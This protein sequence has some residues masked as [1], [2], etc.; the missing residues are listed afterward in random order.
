MLLTQTSFAED[1]VKELPPLNPIYMG[2]QQMVLITHGSNIYASHLSSYKTP[3]NFQLLYK[4][5]NKNVA[6][7][8]T[9]KNNQL[10]TI[11]SKPFNIQRLMRG[12]KVTV[13]VDLYTGHFDRDGMV[14]Y[15]GISLTFDKQLYFR[16]F[17]EIKPSNKRQDYD[18]VSL[19]GG[20]RFYIHQIQK[21]PS[22]S[23]ILGVDL[24][25]S[26]LGSFSTSSP[27]PEETEL[28]FKFINC[29]TIKPLYFETDD[30]K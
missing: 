18:V 11:K 7:L 16:S 8:Q 30:F 23:H 1:K 22:F 5:E 29:G 26:C 20:Y 4:I 13:E 28:Q 2:E 21:A 27:V 10:I 14:V 17:D 3:N 9:V 25:S 6:I 19:K 24:Q 15:E 12:E